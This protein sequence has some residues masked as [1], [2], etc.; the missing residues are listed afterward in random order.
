M[1]LIAISNT[2]FSMAAYIDNIIYKVGDSVNKTGIQNLELIDINIYPN[3][4]NNISFISF[5]NLTDGNVEIVLLDVLGRHVNCVYNGYL[6]SGE[7]SVGVDVSKLN[8]GVYFVKI[9][10]G[11]N[12]S[13]QKLV[14]N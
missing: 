4:A 1:D 9:I 3:P 13:T 6:D 2:L 5:N 10:Q 14:V 11:T 7:V 8:R 12:I